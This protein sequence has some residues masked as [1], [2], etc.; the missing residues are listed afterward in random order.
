MHPAYDTPGRPCSM[1]P[2]ALT[3][4]PQ[5][6]SGQEVTFRVDK[7]AS[8]GTTLLT[9]RKAGPA[10]RQGGDQPSEKT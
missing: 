2:C 9:A 8:W 7:V 3:D 1:L 5:R 4:I 6:H 10:R